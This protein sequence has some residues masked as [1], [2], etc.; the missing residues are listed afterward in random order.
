M[1]LN[2][3]VLLVDDMQIIRK[4]GETFLKN[5][6]CTVVT[7]EDGDQVIEAIRC[8]PKPFDVILLDIMMERSNGIT[9][10]GELRKT[11]GLRCP[12]IAMTAKT[13]LVDTVKYYNV[14]F[15]VVLNKPFVQRGVT[16]ALLEAKRRAGK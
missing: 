12:I 16:A 13:D 8:S 14:G 9:L 7:L 10:C 11:H 4:M 6:G 15:D 1:A 5:L 2:M 3:H